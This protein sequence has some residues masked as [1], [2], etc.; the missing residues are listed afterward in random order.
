MRRS[1]WALELGG[2]RGWSLRDRGRSRTWHC[3]A[4]SGAYEGAVH[5]GGRPAA[6]E[7]VAR[8]SLTTNSWSLGSVVY[9]REQFLPQTV[10]P[11][12]A[13]GR[14]VVRRQAVEEAVVT[15]VVVEVGVEVVV[16]AGQRTVGH[17]GGERDGDAELQLGK[18]GVGDAACACGVESGAFETGGAAQDGREK[19]GGSKGRSRST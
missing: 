4:G 6:T 17:G 1:C 13:V 18:V 7:R 2:Q 8:R 5:L 15:E 10:L 9:E 12:V 14:A 11:A 3:E 16:E 19:A